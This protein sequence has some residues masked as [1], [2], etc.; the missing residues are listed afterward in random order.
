MRKRSLLH[1]L[2]QLKGLTIDRYL[3]RPV[4]QF[5][6][7]TII[8]ISIVTVAVS[9]LTSR[10]GLTIFGKE[11]GEDYAAFYVAGT[12][13]NEYSPDRL[14]DFNLQ[15]QIYHS[16]LPLIPPNQSLPYVN[17]PFFALLFQH[18]SFLSYVSSYLAWLLISGALYIAGLVLVRR[19]I[20]AIPPDAY[21]IA[22][23][24]ALS[25]E[26]FIMECWFGGNSSAFGFFGIVLALHLENKRRPVLSGM[27]LGLCLYKP[28]L[29]FLLLPLLVVARRVK[30]L[31]GFA[32]CVL[33]L[34]GISIL[35]VGWQTCISYIHVLSGFSQMTY[36]EMETLPTWKYVDIL[37][38][39]RLIMGN[40]SKLT[41]VV[42][43]GSS[44]IPLSFLIKAWWKLDSYN[45]DGRSLIWASTLSWTLVFNPHI[46][47]YDTL[48]A[49]IGILLTANVIYRHSCDASQALTPMFKSLIVL[50]YLSP[51]LLHPLARKTGFQAYTLVLA[52][53]GAYQLLLVRSTRAMTA[54]TNSSV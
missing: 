15:K 52:I 17:P 21:S 29:L 46:G 6:S 51:L 12:I 53:I 33:A 39:F 48:L 16:L 32:V 19:S 37:S 26:P 50:L 45:E 10:Q 35:T 11:V 7:V 41:L 28:T 27:A 5:V 38:F 9:I 47:I 4:I 42:I 14:Y 8:V 40:P 1:R 44:T 24:L 25:F 49:V 31:A 54:T 18:L 3:Q 36:G 23:L 2:P 13:L 43:L 30:T 20:Q 34:V 22:I